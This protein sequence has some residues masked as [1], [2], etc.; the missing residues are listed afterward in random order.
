MRTTKGLFDTWKPWFGFFW[1]MNI[2]DHLGLLQLWVYLFFHFSIFL[3]WKTNVWQHLRRL[4]PQCFPDA[5][6]IELGSASAVV[7]FFIFTHHFYA[8]CGDVLTPKK[9]KNV[10]KKQQSVGFASRNASLNCQFFF[11]LSGCCLLMI[12]ISLRL[13]GM[14]PW[15]SFSPFLVGDEEYPGPCQRQISKFYRWWLG[16]WN[17]TNPWENAQD[18]VKWGHKGRTKTVVICHGGSIRISCK[19]YVKSPVMS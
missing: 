2:V 10:W 11:S 5:W 16:W 4:P 9:N 1:N 7:I 15:A 14:L 8:L 3:T 17:R 19:W 18:Q 13:M 6:P 12:S